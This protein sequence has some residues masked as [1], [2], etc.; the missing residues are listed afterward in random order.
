MGIPGDEF[1]VAEDHYRYGHWEDVNGVKT[2]HGRQKSRFVADST[3]C[4]FEPPP[5][6]RRGR[7]LDS[8][9]PAWHKRLARFMPAALARS[10]CVI[11]NVELRRIQEMDETKA[12]AE[13]MLF[14]DGGGIG[15]SGW[16]H[17]INYGVVQRT[18][19][20]AFIVQW[21]EIHGPEAWEKNDWV[22]NYSFRRVLE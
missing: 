18:A 22:W 21:S 15:H 11:T 14:H 1:V 8:E 20:Q 17:R 6:F 9:T 10:K 16:R 19:K 5:E 13:G 2:A 3:E 4:L 7:H 12:R